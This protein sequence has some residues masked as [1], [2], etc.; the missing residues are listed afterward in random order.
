MPRETTQ[1]KIIADLKGNT[2]LYDTISTQ[3]KKMSIRLPDWW[4]QLVKPT[5]LSN[6][7]DANAIHAAF[8]VTIEESQKMQ[9]LFKLDTAATIHITGEFKRFYAFSPSE[10][11]IR[12]SDTESTIQGYG[13]IIIPVETTQ[14]TKQIEISNVAYVPDFYFNII[15]AGALQEKGLYH[16]ALLGWLVNE[17]GKKQYKINKLGRLYTLEKP[18]L[19]AIVFAS[20]PAGSK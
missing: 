13:T 12:H 16:N 20:T 4:P 9:N 7:A 17:N 5:E 14:G 6:T 19:D 2:K 11:P 8:A 3:L 15:S 1:A 10:H 18:H